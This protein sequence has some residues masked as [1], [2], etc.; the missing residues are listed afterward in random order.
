MARIR[1][2]KP[3]F[4]VNEDIAS[5]P[6]VARLLFIGLWCLADREGRLDD[7]PVRIKAQLFPY[8]ECDINDLLDKLQEKGFILRY[9]VKAEKFIQINNFAKHQ[10]CN[11]KEGESTIPTPYKHR[12]STVKAP[13]ENSTDTLGKE[14][15]GKE[16]EGKGKDAREHPLPT[17]VDRAAWGGF[18]EMRQSIKAPLKTERAINIILA[19]LQKFKSKGQDPNAILDQSTS[20]SWKGVFELKEGKNGSRNFA[21]ER[22]DERIRRIR[23]LDSSVAGDV[24][25]EKF[26]QGGDE[27][28]EGSFETVSEVETE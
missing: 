14:G 21:Q 7:R 17:W 3:Q 25:R 22:E 24:H 23:G 6:H 20:N 5:L 18:V 4:F 8:E 26:S 13:V 2:I 11:I 12:T 27:T 15:K 19:R 10:H 1:T 9:S 16:Q 28:L